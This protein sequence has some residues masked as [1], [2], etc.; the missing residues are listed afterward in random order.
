MCLSLPFPSPD[1]LGMAVLVY[2]PS[3][4]SSEVG[5]AEAVEQA[6]CTVCPAQRVLCPLSPRRADLPGP[7]VVGTQSASPHFTVVVVVT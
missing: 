5:M 6:G 1:L 4:S 2:A 7:T 3:I